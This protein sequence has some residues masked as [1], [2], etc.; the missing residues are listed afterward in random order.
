[1]IKNR[2]FTLIEIL[3]VLII[4]AFIMSLIGP[5]LY[6]KIAQSERAKTEIILGKLKGALLSYKVDLQHYP[7]KK[8]V[9]LRALIEKP[10]VPGNEKWDGPYADETD[11]LDGWN[12]E[13]E[14]NCP[15]EKHKDK[16]RS[17]EIISYGENMIGESDISKQIHTGA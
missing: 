14:Y 7:S 17:F 15:P 2:A 9:G 1:M 13:F 10:N 3:V 6:K 8:E 12:Q 16:Y 5:A 4:I 11:L